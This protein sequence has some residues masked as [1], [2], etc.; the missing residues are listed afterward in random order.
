MEAQQVTLQWLTL[1]VSQAKQQSFRW[2]TVCINSQGLAVLLDNLVS[3]LI[4]GLGL[5]YAVSNG[6][7][8][9]A[10]VV[11]LRSTCDSQWFAWFWRCAQSMTV[12]SVRCFC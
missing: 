5:L 9:Y 10:V 7:M 3:F 11:S 8:H 6:T 12:I 2:G 1:C 4:V